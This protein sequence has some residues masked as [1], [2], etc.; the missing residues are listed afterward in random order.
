MNGI[1]LLL[2]GNEYFGWTSAKVSASMDAAAREFAVQMA[3]VNLGALGDSF[4]AA[5]GDEVEILCDGTSVLKGFIN[6]YNP[7]ISGSSHT[8]TINGRGKSQDCVDCSAAAHPTGRFEN[9]TL[10]QIAN[11]LSGVVGIDVSSE[12][13]TPKIGKFQVNQGESIVA[14]IHRLSKSY[15]YSLT[16]LADG[17]M[18]LVR[19]TSSARYEGVYL[20]EGAWPLLSASA[21]I[22]DRQRFSNYTMK[23]QLSGA[24]DRYGVNAAAEVAEVKDGTVTRFRPYVGL[25]DVSSDSQAASSA[26]DWRS[27]RIAGKGVN[28]DVTV[29]GFFFAGEIWEP[30]KL[31]YINSK[32]MKLDHEL[33]IESV[34]YIQDDSGTRTDMKLVPPKAAKSKAGTKSKS[35]EGSGSDQYSL[36][37]TE[38]VTKPTIDLGKYG[39]WNWAD[40]VGAQ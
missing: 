29:Q 31:V 19:G 10:Q 8:V 25:M 18:R 33:L 16:G 24:Q 21:K 15:G 35:A 30:N 11:E 28:V 1:T 2:N 9:L 36:P 32:S 17:S 4:W 6:D 38:R 27:R 3:E 40:Q 7:S 26:A 14:A 20:R 5:P 34:T 13:V 39:E 37:D 22:S 12:E 23:S